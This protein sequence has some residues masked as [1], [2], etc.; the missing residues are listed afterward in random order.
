MESENM[1]A[2][3]IK[4]I[5]IAKKGGITETPKGWIVPS[6][7][8]NGAYLVYKDGMKT[9]CTC[10]DCESRGLECK[11]Q[12]AVK[13][14]YGETK[15]EQGQVTVTKAVRV[16]YPQN[17]KAYNRSQTDEIRLFDAY[18][19]ELVGNVDEPEQGRGRPRLSKQELLFCTIQKVY[20]QLSSRRARS[21][22]LNA[23]D[24]EQI[25]KAPNYNSINIILND[26]GMTPILQDLLVASAMPLRSVETAFAA[27]SSGFRTS[28]FGQYAVEK[29]GTGRHHKWV[30]AHVLVGTK[31]NTIVAAKITEENGADCPQ[32]GPMVTEAHENGFTL[33]EVTADK[34]YA[35][36]ENYN[37]ATRIG[38]TAYIP[39]KAKDTERS[40]GSYTWSKMYHYFMLHRDEFMVHY[41]ARSNVESTFQMVKA[42]FGDKIKSRNWTAQQNELLCKLICHNIV[43][44]IHEVGGLGV[45]P[46]IPHTAKA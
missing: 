21:L 23:K 17:W 14:F 5:E 11:H 8:G 35:S 22:Y 36:R 18:L 44:L 3:T 38:A 31:T 25:V 34:A 2:R 42:K 28:Q 9:A 43:V 13:V 10:P 46:L 29:Y 16:T 45:N 30:K 6:Q 4:G 1:D 15:D 37:T 12:I 32:F 33:M 24:R 27:D 7:N 20:S 26:K 39:F 40:K 41:H 19:R